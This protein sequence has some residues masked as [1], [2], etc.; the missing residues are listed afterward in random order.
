MGRFFEKIFAVPIKMT[1]L[2]PNLMKGY[3]SGI[4]SDATQ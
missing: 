3:S 4:K 1:S 2:I